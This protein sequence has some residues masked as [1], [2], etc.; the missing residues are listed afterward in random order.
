MAKQAGY[1]S[2]IAYK[3]PGKSRINFNSG[4]EAFQRA[5]LANQRQQQKRIL[6]SEKTYAKTSSELYDFTTG[7][8]PSFGTFVANSVSGQRLAK[9]AEYELLKN[10][11][12]SH[13]QF[14][15]FSNNQM[16]GWKA[17]MEYGKNFEKT[18]I[19]YAKNENDGTGG[20]LE[21]QYFAPKFA[22]GADFTDK[23]YVADDSGNPW[24]VK[25]D[26]NRNI[27]ESQS[28]AVNMLNNEQAQFSPN[29]T[30][31]DYAKKF[32]D[33]LGKFKN[34]N[35]SEDGKVTTLEGMALMA[36]GSRGKSFIDSY[37]NVVERIYKAAL[38]N[39]NV[40]TNMLFNYGA[41][42]GNEYFFYDDKGEGEGQ[43]FLNG[44]NK[45]LG[46]F[47][48]RDTDLH[49]RVQLTEGQKNTLREAVI[50]TVNAQLGF[51]KSERISDSIREKY[52]KD[53][54]GG[55]DIS[56]ALKM[57]AGDRAAWTK[58]LR[59]HNAKSKP[60]DA[61]VSYRVAGNGNIFVSYE[62]D[63]GDETQITFGD[64]TGKKDDYDVIKEQVSTLMQLSDPSKF[65]SL[66]DAKTQFE[67][68]KEMLPAGTKMD[69]YS[70]KGGDRGRFVSLSEAEQKAFAEELSY[71][72]V[73]K[74]GGSN[75]TN[76]ATN[77]NKFIDRMNSDQYN[78]NPITRA[79]DPN[80]VI[81]SAQLEYEQG[82][83]FIPAGPSGAKITNLDS[84][85]K[86]KLISNPDTKVQ[87]KLTVRGG[88]DGTDL[89]VFTLPLG[90]IEQGADANA[91]EFKTQFKTVK[92]MLNFDKEPIKGKAA[93]GLN[94]SD[95]YDPGLFKLKL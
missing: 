88:P 47:V 50:E 90:A 22:E 89:Q 93:R 53:E 58:G 23:E 36:G 59:Q 70:F 39:E 5:Q 81:T 66:N 85:F 92:E 10:G 21:T 55:Y 1:N 71:V 95:V 8:S 46:F 15:V 26:K 86:N 41:P 94:F 80:P 75:R 28:G 42:D 40:A 78:F 30:I 54:K 17:F 49:R 67:D 32:T 44:R 25:Y 87:L 3:E 14:N 45:E 27:I 13:S 52:K 83:S 91:S 63:Q 56:L 18:L 34:I 69:E 11:Q 20:A 82:G 72:P 61:I 29:T 37:D 65:K 76:I 73:I 64:F 79:P 35:T 19:Q 24:I 60:G 57:R 12:T 7:I 74:D 6:D 48:N 62:K 33:K 4:L 84:V 2:Y 43:F 51:Q 31:E 38:T 77:V 9:T 16:N 68:S